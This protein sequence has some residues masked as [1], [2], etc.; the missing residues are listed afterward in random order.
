MQMRKTMKMM[1]M[2][3]RSTFR[4]SSAVRTT[5]KKAG[6]SLAPGSANMVQ[7]LQPMTRLQFW[8]ILLALPCAISVGTPAVAQDARPA[9]SREVVQALPPEGTEQLN[10]ALRRLGRDENDK[11]ALLDA[12]DAALQIG[13]ND[14]AIG[15]FTRLIALE[16]KHPSALAGLAA[17]FVRRENPFEALR[18][19]EEAEAAGA[20]Q[21]AYASDRGLAFDLVGDNARAQSV[22]R[23]ALSEGAN[24]GISLRLAMSQAIAGDQAGSED[25]LLPFLQRSNL[26]AYRIRA[27]ALAALGKTEEAV[28]IA[29]TVMPARLSSR[30]APY[31]RYMPRLTKAQQAAA[32]H[33]GIFPHPSNIGK[34]DPRVAAYQSGEVQVAVLAGNGPRSSAQS[35][36]APS[37]QPLGPSVATPV[38]QQ[39]VELPQPSTASVAEAFADFDGPD[40]V[41]PAAGAVDITTITP[42]QAK[43]QPLH[44]RRHWVQVATGR[45]R[46]ALRFDWR[47]I[48]RNSDGELEGVKGYLADWGQTNRLLAGPFDSEGEAQDMVTRL[49]REKI[50]SF[51]FT[52]GDGEVI[53]PLP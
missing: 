44:P 7:T 20:A 31:L 46:G 27:F 6:A 4:V 41:A 15:F 49:A 34:D 38:V 37:G 10:D 24:E 30:M 43:P 18:I 42:A 52:S 28:T 21:D 16:P 8:T 39:V 35:R 22:Y 53:E 5:S 17:T 9:I 2:V 11:A 40:A 29:E 48:V 13:D 1:T 19:F 23:A 25:T 36:F 26:A 14:A 33:L 51:T 50:D 45:D 12:G 3:R 47:R 32:A